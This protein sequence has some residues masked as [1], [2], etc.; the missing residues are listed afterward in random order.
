MYI[1]RR[2]RIVKGNPFGKIGEVIF[3]YSVSLPGDLKESPDTLKKAT[4]TWG[5][6]FK[7]EDGSL[8]EAALDQVEWLN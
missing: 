7:A 4:Y 6:T 1:G 3:E 5:F 2:G 8:F